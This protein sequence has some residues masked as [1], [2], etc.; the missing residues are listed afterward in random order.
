MQS[1]IVRLLAL[2]CWAGALMSCVS[3]P[4]TAKLEAAPWDESRSRVVIGDVPFFPQEAYQCGPAALATLLSFSGGGVLPSMLVDEVFVPGR[5]G[6][7]QVEMLAATRSRG[8]LAYQIAPSL[9]DLLLE[10]EAGNPVL[11]LQNLGLSIRPQWHFAVAKGYDLVDQKIILNSGTIE[12][13]RLSLK[14][15]ERT[16]ARAQHWAVVINTPGAVPQT[17]TAENYFQSILDLQH[18]FSDPLAIQLAYEAGL[19]KWPEDKQ[20]LIG[21][22]NHF[23]ALESYQQ[24][25]DVYALAVAYYPSY[26]P[27]LNN[28]AHTLLLLGDADAALAY[29]EQAVVHAVEYRD[30]YQKTY[31]EIVETIELNP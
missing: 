7:F 27:A 12:G 22:G 21:L 14:T 13:Y 19:R 8:R 10:V 26:S 1:R 30:T 9:S 18:S 16:W 15:F 5:N 20:L 17:A 24:A 11:V 29:A 2:A 6:S 3:T 28:L 23:L 4:Q 31:T 25:A